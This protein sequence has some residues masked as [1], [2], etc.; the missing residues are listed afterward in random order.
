MLAVRL[1]L[2]NRPIVSWANMHTHPPHKYDKPVKLS[3]F[4]HEYSIWYIFLTSVRDKRRV[5][6]RSKLLLPQQ[7]LVSKET[8]R[9]TVYSSYSAMP[10]IFAKFFCRFGCRNFWRVE[11]KS[12][13]ERV[14]W[15]SAKLWLFW[16][17]FT[18]RI[19]AISKTTIL[20]RSWSIGI[21]S[22]LGWS[23]I[24]VLSS[25]FLLRWY[26]WLFTYVPVVWA[27]AVGY[28]SSIQPPWMSASI[29]AFILT[30][31]LRGWLDEENH[32][33]AGFLASNCTW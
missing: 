4:C 33:Q 19:T 24:T 32:P 14:P 5:S 25:S 1:K 31:S 12:G 30:R 27:N 23:A 29:R 2:F 8:P 9:W 6:K 26:R 15:R 7:K 20:S 17:P 13:N 11:L 22:F 16:S 18:S 21:P 28:L 10:M 3:Q